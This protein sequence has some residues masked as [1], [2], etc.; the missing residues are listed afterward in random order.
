MDPQRLTV[1]GIGTEKRECGNSP[2]WSGAL[3]L[4]RAAT[5]DA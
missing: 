4:V 5:R 2:G 3:D 1:T